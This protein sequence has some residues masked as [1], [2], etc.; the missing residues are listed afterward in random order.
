M[1]ITVLDGDQVVKVTHSAQ[2]LTVNSEQTN[3]KSPL[4][5]LRQADMESELMKHP[6][7]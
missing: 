5:Q 7:V 4:Y 6:T 1:G 2:Q 3:I